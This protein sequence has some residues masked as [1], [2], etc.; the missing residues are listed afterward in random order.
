MNEEEAKQI[1]KNMDIEI[2]GISTCKECIYDDTNCFRDGKD[3]QMQAI[4]TVLNLIAKQKAEIEDKQD[5]INVLEAQRDSIENQFEQAKAEIEKKDRIIDE[6]AKG[7]FI[8]M[9]DY[10]NPEE[11]KQCF[12][13]K[14][15][16]G[17]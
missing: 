9:N 17:N 6:M 3:C 15:E 12:E 13:R 7:I 14:V 5:E 1:L 16:N 10:A 8:E 2:S 4:E 11:V